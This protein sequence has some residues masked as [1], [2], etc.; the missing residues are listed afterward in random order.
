MSGSFSGIGV[1]DFDNL[2][3]DGNTIRATNSGGDINLYPLD[4]SVIISSSVSSAII[5]SS[6]T[7]GTIFT[8]IPPS[9]YARGFSFYSGSSISNSTKAQFGAYGQSNHTVER[10][11]MAFETVN[12]GTSHWSNNLGIYLVSGST[13]VRFGVLTVAPITPFDVS[14]QG[15]FRS[16]VTITGSALVSGTMSA[17]AVSASRFIGNAADTVSTPTFT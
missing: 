9:S 10:M 11:Y 14:G 5:L 17:S 16:G 15:N 6:E 1:F 8:R 12:T 2:R 3:I 7:G 13:G 4:G